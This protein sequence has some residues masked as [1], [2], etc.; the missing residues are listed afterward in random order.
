MI[1]LFVHDP[2]LVGIPNGRVRGTFQ[3]GANR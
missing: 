3:P 1:N 2:D